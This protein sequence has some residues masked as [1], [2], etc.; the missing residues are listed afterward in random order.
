MSNLRGEYNFGPECFLSATSSDLDSESFPATSRR[1]IR[2][3]AP[4][5]L[6]RSY[7]RTTA[8]DIQLRLEILCKAQAH[9]SEYTDVLSMIKILERLG[10]MEEDTPSLEL[11][12]Y[13]EVFVTI[14]SGVKA[15]DDL[16]IQLLSFTER[17]TLQGVQGNAECVWRHAVVNAALRE[18]EGT[19]L[20]GLDDE[21][22][23]DGKD[24]TYAGNLRSLAGIIIG[25]LL[26]N[27]DGFPE[28]QRWF[29]R[30]EETRIMESILRVV[31][32]AERKNT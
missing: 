18:L 9:T 28:G 31:K 13:R 32:E 6:N 16:P 15:T 21:A 19:R 25:L 10:N 26:D 7:L 27:K 22:D 20:G 2:T 14:R 3:L 29:D 1:D 11:A 12:E 8:T 23:V 24:V 17:S 30:E 5:R 4:L